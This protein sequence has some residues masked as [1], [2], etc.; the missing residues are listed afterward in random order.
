M[1]CPSQCMCRSASS[2]LIFDLFAVEVHVVEVTHGH[3]CGQ[4][5][6]HLAV[7]EAAVEVSVGVAATG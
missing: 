6:D 5:H 1:L 4:D 3:Q 7:E 2:C